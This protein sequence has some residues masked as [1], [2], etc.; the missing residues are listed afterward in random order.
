MYATHCTVEDT[1]TIS[2]T[3]APKNNGENSYKPGV[4]IRRLLK[5]QAHSRQRRLRQ[6]DATTCVPE[7]A[8]IGRRIQIGDVEAADDNGG[9]DSEGDSE[10]ADAK[11]GGTVNGGML[12]GSDDDDDDHA[13]GSYKGHE[14]E[15]KFG[16]KGG[17][18]C[19]DLKEG[20]AISPANV[21]LHGTIVAQSEMDPDEGMCI[22]GPVC[23]IVQY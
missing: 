2:L 19:S 7:N 9:G 1:D 8:L 12:S 6:I 16:A 20:A 3:A 14:R 11:W 15:C 18:K 4:A 22:V 10:S 13:D 5:A 21:K 23:A 17:D